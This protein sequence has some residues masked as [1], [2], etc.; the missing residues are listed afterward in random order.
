MTTY[1]TILYQTK[2]NVATLTLNRPERLNAFTDEMMLEIHDTLQRARDDSSIRAIVLTGAGRA[3]CAGQDISSFQNLEDYDVE[4]HLLATYKP[5]IELMRAIEKPIIGA[6]NGV[7]AGAGCSLALACDLRIMAEEAS[8]LQAFSNI[9]LI[10][11]AGST[12]FL[13]RQVGYSR[14][15]EI[16]SEGERIPAQ[17]CLELGLTNRVV[18]GDVLMVEAQAWA[19]KL[20][21]RATFAIGLTKQAMNYAANSTLLEA[22]E[23]EARLQ[24][25]AAASQDFVEG[26]AAFKEKRKP[27][28]EGR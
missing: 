26:V 13:V 21:Q 22:I 9:G 10:P 18:K 25:R 5:M 24:K 2:N 27:L 17:R 12:W 11:D 6:I 7:A 16:A 4:K 20:A 1:Q 3:F 8:L 14:A 19:E 15:F 28:F 23:F